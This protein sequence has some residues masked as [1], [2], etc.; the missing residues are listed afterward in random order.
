MNTP[1]GDSHHPT[2][3]VETG[4]IR[5]PS[6]ARSLLLRVTR[7]CP[8]NRCSFCPVYRGAKFSIR[9]VAEVERDIRELGR[10]AADLRERS[11]GAGHG[12]EVSRGALRDV[13]ARGGD[14]MEVVMVARFLAAGGENVFIQDA[15][16]LAMPA[17]QLGQILETLRRTFPSITR[18]TSYA[19]AHTLT[20]RRPEELKALR[21]LGLNRIHVGLESG[22]DRVLTLVRKGVDAARQIEAGLAVKAAGMELSEYLM[23]GLG[24]RELWRE[25]A[26]ESARVLSAIDPHFI[27]LRTTAVAPGTELAQL[28][29]RGEMTPMDDEQ[30][31]E[32]IRL[33]IENLEATSCLQSDHVLNLL[34]ELHGELPGDRP[35]LLDHIARFQSMDRRL[36]QA[37]ILARRAGA[38]T[39]PDDMSRPALRDRAL[40]MYDQLVAHH[41]GDMAAAVR[42]LML[43][44]I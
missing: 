17:D 10:A 26:L 19:R 40:A 21:R 34:S 18:I 15:N 32:E 37:F 43:R 38:L 2:H 29:E 42:S 44:F 4:P 35:F 25:H 27:R 1:E 16:S 13:L 33:F 28:V 30:I 8:W 39:T 14:R 22:S 36:R 41:D 12:G 31:V 5:P 9:K 7:N 23:P 3:R 11:R 20:R 6:E 24:G